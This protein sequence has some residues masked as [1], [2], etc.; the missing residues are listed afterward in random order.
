MSATILQ[1]RPKL[2]DP[3][4]RRS[5]LADHYHLLLGMNQRQE[6]MAHKA[7]WRAGHRRE[8]ME[9]FLSFIVAS[10]EFNDALE[11]YREELLKSLAGKCPRAAKRI[12]EGKPP[13][14]RQAKRPVRSAVDEAV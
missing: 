14:R 1:F 10:R 7:S 4:A 12:R 8:L 2:T 6:S 9:A 13:R 11:A 5:P 3:L